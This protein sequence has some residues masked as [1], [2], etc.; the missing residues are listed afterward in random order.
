MQTTTTAIAPVARQGHAVLMTDEPRTPPK[1]SAA[2]NAVYRAG[3]TRK[4]DAIQ[5]DLGEVK[6]TLR[7]LLEPPPAPP[8]GR[9]AEQR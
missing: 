2:R 4:L 8:R 1:P 9:K 6:A 5:K 7:E 3:M